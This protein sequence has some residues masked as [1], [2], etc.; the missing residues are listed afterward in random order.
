MTSPGSLRAQ[1]RRRGSAVNEDSYWRPWT[2]PSRPR[3]PLWLLH[4]TPCPVI[5]IVKT[6]GLTEDE[7][8]D[9]CG[10]AVRKD[11][12][13]L[14]TDVADKRIV[15]VVP[16][17]RDS[18]VVAAAHVEHFA[19]L[20]LNLR[21]P[22]EADYVDGI[23]VF[24]RFL[25]PCG[26]AVMPDGA[27]CMITDSDNHR[28]RRIDD[29]TDYAENQSGKVSTR[30]RSVAGIPPLPSAPVSAA[31]A[32]DGGGGGGGGGGDNDDNDA[33][34]FDAAAGGGG[35]AA[36]GGGGGAAAASLALLATTVTGEAGG[37]AASDVVP[38]APAA[39]PAVPAVAPAALAEPAVDGADDDGGND[40]DGETINFGDATEDE[41]MLFPVAVAVS[42]AG[43]SFVAESGFNRVLHILEGGAMK[44]LVHSIPVEKL[45]HTEHLPDSR[46]ASRTGGTC[47]AGGG[48]GG[49]SGGGGAAGAAEQQEQTSTL[50]YPTDVTVLP[51]GDVV[52]VDSGHAMVQRI[53]PEGRVTRFAG[54]TA[55][56]AAAANAAPEA[57]ASVEAAASASESMSAALAAAAAATATFTTEHGDGS[58]E[59][60]TFNDPYSIACDLEGRVVV[61]DNIRSNSGGAGGDADNES[62]SPDTC[63]LR[64]VHQELGVVASLELVDNVSG[65]PFLLKH[66]TGIDIDADGNIV[67]C[68]QDGVFKVLNTGLAGGASA[69]RKMLWEPTRR[70]R[71]R[72]CSA[73]AKDAAVCL[74]LVA[75]RFDVVWNAS[76]RVGCSD[77]RGDGEAGADT[78]VAEECGGSSAALGTVPFAAAAAAA[79]SEVRLPLEM[80][81][82]IL[83]MIE[84]CQLGR[85]PPI[86]DVA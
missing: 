34:G 48:G 81:H 10:I 36:A 21:S 69:W 60:A 43:E 72:W 24:A 28:L 27:S 33:V 19:G 44:S 38:A 11:N 84:P 78:T 79:A 64:V 20:P 52:V 50:A 14:V 49:G 46:E 15:K 59:Y 40:S 26:I 61:T 73:H 85:R 75:V 66:D 70:C 16:P 9:P 86:A 82:H 12:T 62:M 31:A 55:A 4:P 2:P 6:N 77:G 17:L 53:S 1:M 83:S 22:K 58:L 74:L 65:K 68:N 54:G 35:G 57:A 29:L 32:A 51:N 7:L 30:V 63:L 56:L 45:Q 8:K 3:T 47:H 25:Y 42:A 37:S 39:P 18:A 23:G 71:R 41:I 5:T 76:N 13:Y 67:C 80:W